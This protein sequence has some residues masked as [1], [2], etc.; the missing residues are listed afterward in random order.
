MHSG[1]SYE[2]FDRNIAFIESMDRVARKLSGANFF[3]HAAANTNVDSCE[4]DPDGC[5]RDNFLL[6][7]LL[8]RACLLANIPFIFI[9]STGIYGEA[10]VVP[11]REYDVVIPTT[12]Y[13][14]SKRLSEELV[15]SLSPR[16]LI[17]RTGWLFGGDIKNP[18]NFV[19]K[20]IEEAFAAFQ[21]RS[22]LASN[23]EQFGVP[24]Y[25]E[26]IATRILLLTK[27]GY[28]GIFNCV[29]EGYATRRDYVE[30]IVKAANI[31]LHVIGLKGKDF[32]RVAKV[33]NNEMADNWKM[34]NLAMPDMPNWEQS[35]NHYIGSILWGK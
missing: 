29:N 20:R 11:Y 21:S 5:Y 34:K 24:C 23:A 32:P 6:T 7:E 1:Y 15:L 10:K 4:L 9:S 12:H 27:L 19:A 31:N 13:H 35:L 16:N 28:S 30:A 26:D 25:A 22:S 3:L 17:I 33:S 14:K 2:E 8:A 18:K